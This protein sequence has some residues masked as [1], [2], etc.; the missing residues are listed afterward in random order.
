MLIAVSLVLPDWQVQPRA[1]ILSEGAPLALDTVVAVDEPGEAGYR[2]AAH[3]TSVP[4][5]AV[6]PIIDLTP[7]VRSITRTCRGASE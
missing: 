5:L 4:G 6:K 1:P 7:L 2:G 3:S